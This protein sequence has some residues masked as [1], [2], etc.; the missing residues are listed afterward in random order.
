MSDGGKRLTNNMEERRAI[1]LEAAA[2]L[3]AGLVTSGR[4]QVPSNPSDYLLKVAD[5][6]NR[7]IEH[8]E[9]P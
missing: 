6:Y 3:L 4:Y 9:V 7:Y 5:K 8:G 1:A 2:T